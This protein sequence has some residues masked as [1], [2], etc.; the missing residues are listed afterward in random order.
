MA[1]YFLKA[2]ADG[3]LFPG[4][5][6]TVRGSTIWNSQ[7]AHVVCGHLRFGSI[8]YDEN[9]PVHFLPMARHIICYRCGLT[10]VF[11]STNKLLLPSF[12]AHPL[13]CTEKAKIQS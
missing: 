6:L 4:E 8:I 13:Y 11:Y 1:N 3:K 10:L 12:K 7:N 9:S 5:H 2:L